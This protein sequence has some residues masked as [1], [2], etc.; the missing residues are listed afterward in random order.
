MAR[1]FRT[2]NKQSR[3][4]AAGEINMLTSHTDRLSANLDKQRDI[5]A[6]GD[7]ERRDLHDSEAVALVELQREFD[8]TSQKSDVLETFKK[9]EREAGPRRVPPF[10][11]DFGTDSHGVGPRTDVR[12]IANLRNGRSLESDLA[13]KGWREWKPTARQDLDNLDDSGFRSTSDF[14]RSV[15]NN[16]AGSYDRRLESLSMAT[17]TGSGGGFLLPTQFAQELLTSAVLAE[18]WL[19]LRRTFELGAGSGQNLI[20]PTLAD[21]DRSG[22]E[23]AGFALS[24]A[25][26]G[27]T[28]SQDAIV[29]GQTNLQLSK[30]G[31][32]IYVSNELMHDSAI[33]VEGMVNDVFS[34]AIALTQAKDTISGSGASEPLGISNGLDRATFTSVSAAGTLT[35]GEIAGMVSKLEPT[36]G[37]SQ[38]WVAH[39]GVFAAL[40]KMETAGNALVWTSSARDVAPRSLMGHPIHFSDSCELLNTAGDLWLGNWDQF[41]YLRGPL[42]VD[43]DRSFRFDTDET[44]F[45]ITMRDAGM[46]WRGTGMTDR[47][48]FTMANFVNLS[49]RS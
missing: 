34:R 13:R 10:A 17:T 20:I 33:G 40:A 42:S 18:P 19:G 26:E 4:I 28:L 7:H 31:R 30:A 11:P 22:S 48:G 41:V 39:F 36:S 38:A 45:R 9:L 43:I 44:A 12:E 23:I 24:R 27:G 49:V 29:L 14:L 16:A 47:K 5:I 15:K 6:L 35:V 8:S 32:V 21:S 37:T 1:D 25:A 2:T 3:Q 46:P